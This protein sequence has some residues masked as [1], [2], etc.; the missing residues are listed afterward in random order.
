[1]RKSQTRRR[2]TGKLVSSAGQATERLLHL[3]PAGVTAA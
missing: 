1:M 2:K 3:Q